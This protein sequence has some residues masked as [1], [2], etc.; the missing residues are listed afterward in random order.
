MESLYDVAYDENEEE[1]AEITNSASQSKL[2]P[3]I[4][5]TIVKP[6][7]PN[8]YPDVSKGLLS[9]IPTWISHHDNITSVADDYYIG[10]LSYLRYGTGDHFARHQDAGINGTSGRIFS[11]S[12]IISMTEDLKGGDFYIWDN[13]NGS[14]SIDLEPGD[15]LFFDSRTL[16][17]ITTVLSGTREVLVAWIYKR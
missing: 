8:H 17:E 11:T 1:A 9:L 6:L 16:H 3:Y 2:D 4:R 5:S 10:E 15:T 13:V 12:T 7:H 14:H